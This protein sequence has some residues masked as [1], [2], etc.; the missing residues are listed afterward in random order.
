M[1]NKDLALKLA[2]SETETDIISLLKDEGYWDNEKC[3]QPF[4]DNENNYSI[5]GNQQSAPDAALVEKL[6]NSIDAVLMKECMLKEIKVDG[7]LAPR[8]TND[9]MEQFFGVKNGNLA[10]IG[11][12]RRRELANNIV[13][14]ATGSKSHI[15]LS[16]IDTGEGQTPARM[17]D[18]LLSLSKSNKLRVPFVQGKFNM[19]GTGVLP[20][21]GE[22]SFELIISKRCPD[23]KKAPG[24]DTF[25]KWTV[26]IVRRENARD[27][28]RSSMYSYLTDSDGN[29]LTF[30]CDQLPLIP[31]KE[32]P[33]SPL[34]YGT[35]QKLYNYGLKRSQTTNIL[36]DLNY[37]ISLLMPDTALPILFKEC[38]PGY[39]GHSFDVIMHGLTTRLIDDRN[40]NIE[41]GFP[42]SE[43]YNVDGQKFGITV[44]A[45]KKEVDEKGKE[46]AKSEKYRNKAGVIFV[47]NGQTQGILS[48]AFFKN[49]N[50]SYLADSLLVVV[51]CSEVDIRHTEDMFMNSRDRLRDTE[52]VKE[53]RQSL[54]GLLK[55]H[56]GLKKL[57][58]ARRSE[59]VKG[60]VEDNK[61]II[62]VVQAVLKNSP[63][64]SKIFVN[65]DAIKSPFNFS[66]NDEED[67]PYIGKD[68][69]TFFSMS[70]KGTKKVPKNSDFKIQFQ[71]DAVNDY[72]HRNV[73]PGKIEISVDGE[74]QPT[75]LNHLSLFNGKGT[76]TLHLPYTSEAGNEFKYSIHLIDDC[77]PIFPDLECSVLVEKEKQKKTNPSSGSKKPKPTGPN[78]GNNPTP[79]A[80]GIPE[81]VEVSSSQWADFDMNSESGMVLRE[82]DD[83]S[84]YFINMDNKYLLTEI[85]NT[86]DKDQIEITRTKY[87]TALTLITM[88]IESHFKNK[89]QVEDAED[90]NEIGLSK[91]VELITSIVSPIIIPTIDTLSNLSPDQ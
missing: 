45:F 1:N 74:K 54:Q 48:E 22:N 55:T 2:N 27:G 76:L 9:A 62:N 80:V 82:S 57:Q 65:G 18:T 43:I 28:R 73:D 81:I 5:I 26:T 89:K 35:F 36:F 3:W 7:P 25:N 13:L 91:A 4:G 44:Y 78:P 88:S 17:K 11:S 41:N 14:A 86:K 32:H 47:V 70:S 66:N 59:A 49:I 21:C 58:H 31:D 38:R 46:K 15:N 30:E 79:K 71:T 77:C 33:N 56:D 37:R 87:K 39:K 53:L 16:I 90:H 10:N 20:F 29:L 52:F 63:V 60:K 69:P 19:G 50:L 24:D 61:Q 83:G 23:L 68:H 64:L 84:D 8:S 34:E 85:K 6:V 40:N 72:F 67:T 12:D 75:L 42:F 51:D